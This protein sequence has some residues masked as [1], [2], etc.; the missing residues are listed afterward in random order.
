MDGGTVTIGGFPVGVGVGPRPPAPLP[1]GG[2]AGVSVALVVAVR[3]DTPFPLP[4]RT[5]SVHSPGRPV[6]PPFWPFPPFGPCPLSLLSADR[7]ELALRY[8][9]L[10]PLPAV[11]TRRPRLGWCS[12]S[13][14]YDQSRLGYLVSR[15]R[16]RFSDRPRVVGD[17]DCPRPRIRSMRRTVSLASRPRVMNLRI[18]SPDILYSAG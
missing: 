18:S 7:S 4:F 2:A 10:S 17:S 15:G 11:Y 6:G 14:S 8:P 13:P 16:S 1:L 5:T 12:L 3:D 9:C